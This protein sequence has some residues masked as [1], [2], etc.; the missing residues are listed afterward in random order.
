MQKDVVKFAIS[1]AILFT[2]G[3]DDDT[4]RLCAPE[5]WAESFGPTSS[6]NDLNGLVVCGWTLAYGDHDK[7][8]CGKRKNVFGPLWTKGE[9][10]VWLVNES[11][12][13]SVGE[14][15]ITVVGDDKE[16]LE[17]FSKDCGHLFHSYTQ[18][19]HTIEKNVPVVTFL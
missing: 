2:D 6:T 16:S 19:K 11:E 12:H 4:M 15:E 17:E 18:H 8:D 9:H 5:C 3:E 1:S 13:E 10:K 14:Y 7:W